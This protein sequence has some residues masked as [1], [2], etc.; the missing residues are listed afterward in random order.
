M[1]TFLITLVFVFVVAF[2]LAA[3]LVGPPLH[4]VETESPDTAA[5]TDVLGRTV[6]VRT[7]VRR[8]ILGEGRQLYLVAALD[9]ADPLQRVVGWRNDLMQ[10]DPATYALYRE[11][12]PRLAALPQFGRIQDGSFDVERALALE[13]DVVVLNIEDAPS[14]DAQR[15]IE[16][17]AKVGI[18]VVYVDFRHK[19]V[20]NTVPTIRLLGRMLG[21]EQRA[22]ALIAFREAQIRKVTDVLARQ[23]PAAPKVF[24]ERIGGYSQDCCLTFGDENFGR[25]V[26]LAGGVNIAK[27]RVPTFG[28]LHPEGVLAADPDHVVVTS[29]NWEAYA[30]GGAWIGVGP[31]ADAA[32]ARR[33][34][35]GYLH[36]PAY[37]GIAAQ[38]TRAFH[39]IWHQFYNSPYQFVAIQQLAKWFHPELFAGLDPDAAFREL[40]ERFLPVPYRP[41]Y[42]VSLRDAGTG[43]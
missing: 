38:R 27:G 39:A 11:R 2:A 4:R 8:M 30:P 41:G 20:E 23:R 26:E 40:H 43:P 10:A 17:L 19:P 37:S 22:E 1:K 36:R 9:T 29:A 33:Q 16:R 13:P 21:R 31:G 25:Y 32:Q 7:P 34:L 14:E 35:E 42:F 6:Q 3:L 28:Q 12:F 18:A 15:T 5:V 24:I